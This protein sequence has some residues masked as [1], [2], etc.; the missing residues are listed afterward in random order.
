MEA[1]LFKNNP[2]NCDYLLLSV[3]EQGLLYLNQDMP[4]RVAFFVDNNQDLPWHKRKCMVAII[5]KNLDFEKHKVYTE[6]IFK[7]GLVD[8]NYMISYIKEMKKKIV[9]MAMDDMD[10]FDKQLRLEDHT[11]EAI[12]ASEEEAKAE[13]LEITS[14]PVEEIKEEINAL[15]VSK[16]LNVSPMTVTNLVKK[17]LIKGE[18]NGAE[19]SFIKADIENLLKELPD[20]LTKAWKHSRSIA[21]SGGYLK[22]IV[23]NNEKYIHIREARVLLSLSE[24]TITKRVQAGLIRYIKECSRTYYVSLSHIEELKANPPDWLKKSWSYFTNSK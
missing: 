4:L 23:R 9:K 22:E 5:G 18:H 15:Q 16:I 24:G 14:E 7:R 8:K 19:W 10:I 20:F 11:Q 21:R 1:R 2:G 6:G 17:G 3:D 12:Q 13:P